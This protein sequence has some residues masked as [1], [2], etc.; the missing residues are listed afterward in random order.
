MLHSC[1]VDP[2]AERLSMLHR[3]P[4]PGAPEEGNRQS[5]ALVLVQEEDS[6]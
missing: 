2:R 3:G 5:I 1:R 6:T 4:H